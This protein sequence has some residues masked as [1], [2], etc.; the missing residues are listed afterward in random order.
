M[1]NPRPHFD[2]P[3]MILG[4]P[5]SGTS[6]IQ[7]VLRGCDGAG[8]VAA[9]AQSIWGVYTH[10]G[11]TGW[12]AE[13]L[14][15]DQLSYSDIR[16]I[17]ERFARAVLPAPFWRRFDK[18]SVVERQHRLG[19]PEW[20]R[21]LAHHGL[22]IVARMGSSSLANIRLTEKSVHAGL[23]PELVE[24][25][26]PDVRF[27]HIVRDP[28]ATIDSITRGWLTP[29]R[30]ET[31]RPPQQLA[32]P[33]GS[34]D[35][36]NFPLP[37]GWRHYRCSPVRDIAAFQWT[38]IN[39]RILAY[40]EDKSDRFLRIRLEDLVEQPRAQ[41]ERLSR[42]AE[43]GWQPHLEKFATEL[44]QVNADNQTRRPERLLQAESGISDERLRYAVDAMGRAFGYDY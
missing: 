37:P 16:W 7:Q 41:L 10:P 17:R 21:R 19:L 4:A 31:Y 20:A 28:R 3:V 11:P 2:R 33:D 25:V 15:P 1:T 23:W 24:A 14:A 22:F 39:R 13:G 27:V 26:F 12:D 34:S 42:F 32:I 38:A 40:A 18:S 9:E 30:F 44:P 29:G 43:F 5:R 6:L 36:W 8:A 35:A